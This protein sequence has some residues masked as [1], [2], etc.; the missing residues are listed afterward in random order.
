MYNP[1]SEYQTT[2]KHSYCIE[3]MQGCSLFQS[4]FR[5]SLICLA[6]CG[7]GLLGG[8]LAKDFRLS[9]GFLT[10]AIL[11]CWWC[12]KKKVVKKRKQSRGR[13]GGN[14]NEIGAIGSQ[15]IT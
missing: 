14:E 8:G 11:Y 10:I 12:S 2:S 13:N 6:V 1:P 3:S 7:S 15:E 4:S 9:A 5:L